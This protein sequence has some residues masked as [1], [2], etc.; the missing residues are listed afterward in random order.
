MDSL[1]ADRALVRRVLKELADI[2]YSYGALEKRILFDETTDNY[3]VVTV[4]WEHD[5]QRAHGCLVHVEIR[6]GKIWIQRDGTEDGVA[7]AFLE[8]GIPKER[9]VLGFHSPARRALTG[10]AA[11]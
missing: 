2:P 6:D 8:A 4:G 9:I 1:V 3:A 7:N 5:G 11:A 10:F